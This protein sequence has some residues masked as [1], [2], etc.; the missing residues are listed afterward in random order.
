MM[1][2]S[3][4][5]AAGT[6]AAAI[7]LSAAAQDWPNWRGP[8]HDGRS[9][10]KGFQTSWASAPPRVWLQPIGSGFSGLS[11]VDGKVYTCGTSADRQTLVCLDAR[12]GEPRWQVPLE[13]GYEDGQGGD[14][15]RGTPTVH[16]GR[17]YVQGAWGKVLCVDAETGTEI[18]HH[19]FSNKPEWGY[20]ASVLIEGD[21]AVVTGDNALVALNKKT[22]EQVWSAGDTIVGYATPYP[23]TFENR[24]YIVAFMG[25]EV[26]IV[27]AKTGRTV[28]RMPWETS[29]NVNAATPIYHDGRLLVSSGYKHGSVLL[30]LAPAGDKLK[31]D[32]VWQ[33]KNIRAKFQSP[34]LYDGYL[35]ASDEVGL[36]C[37][38]FASGQ[39]KWKKRGVKHG[40]VVIADGQL[41]VLTEDGRLLVGPATPKGWQ[42][43]ANVS[44]SEGRHWTVP[45]L[46]NGRLYVRNLR[47][48][49][50]Y[51]LTG[52]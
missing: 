4:R 41:L 12:T 15:C 34:V 7:T 2:L 52:G 8:N 11:C 46:S 9:T 17:V 49:A 45:T 42:P 3:A 35:Y 33:N 10:A 39:E 13:R 36:K 44:L 37:V 43:T 23:F 24:R 5:L 22:G 30:K 16:D 32:T 18:W 27:E 40:T 51:N 47:E 48:A 20:S 31:T 50:C 6:L 38:E 25:K 28:W 1:Y 21:L 19:D 29:W 14:G 26:F